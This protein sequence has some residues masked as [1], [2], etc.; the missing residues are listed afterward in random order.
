MARDHQPIALRRTQRTRQQ[1][2]LDQMPK[3]PGPASTRKSSRATGA[4]QQKKPA[5]ATTTTT[6]ATRTVG[7]PARKTKKTKASV[8]ESASVATAADDA[9]D[10]SVTLVDDADGSITALEFDIPIS[11]SPRRNNNKRKR[12]PSFTTTATSSSPSSQN[13]ERTPTTIKKVRR[14]TGT[15]NKNWSSSSSPSSVVHIL[16]LRT[17]ILDDHIKR[18]IRRNGLSAEMNDA[19]G[20]KRARRQ[21]TL[22]ELRRARDELRDR[23]AEIERLRELTALFGDGC[24]SQQ[25]THLDLEMELSRLREEVLGHRKR[26]RGGGGGDDHDDVELTSSPPV[27]AREDHDDDH[28]HDHD[29]WGGMGGMSDDG[30]SDDA[31]GDFGVHDF[32]DDDEF[33][34][35]SVAELDSGGTLG[36]HR[37]HQQPN[38]TAETRPAALH[39]HGMITLTPPSTSPAKLASSPVRQIHSSSNGSSS[40][41]PCDAGVQAA[42]T[43]SATD[44]ASQV[45]LPAP[46]MDALHEELGVLRAEVSSLNETLQGQDALRARVGEKLARHQLSAD[47][48]PSSAQAEGQGQDFELQLDIVLQDLAEKTGRLAELSD[49]LMPVPPSSSSSSTNGTATDNKQEATAQ[50][51]A[52]LQSVRDTLADLDPSVTPLPQSAAPTLILAATRLREL[53]A[54]LRQRTAAHAAE[55]SA[56]SADL[57]ASRASEAEK[58]TQVANLSA[59]IAHLADTIAALRDEVDTLQSTSASQQTDLDSARDAALQQKTFAAEA[60][61]RLAEA[62]ARVSLLS[63][64]LGERE[65]ELEGRDGEVGR[66]RGELAAA[67]VTIAKLRGDAAREMGRSRDVVRAMRAQMVAALRVGEGFLGEDVVAAKTEDGVGGVV[68]V[69]GGN[70]RV[71]AAPRD[72]SDDSGL[73]LEDLGEG[74]QLA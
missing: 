1:H 74:L 7:R 13:G 29:G 17:Q 30:G 2:R 60:E 16:P 27:A 15:N 31:G 32:D 18:R 51:S 37:Q 50:L 26:R 58:T 44:A 56:L 6:T 71:I 46:A 54:A 34:E 49:L 10:D 33:G 24:S 43:M 23:D 36:Q 39:L 25:Q 48:S 72:P 66:L 52:A 45:C 42:A 21:K 69:V 14:H 28:D 67:G 62:V 40:M 4:A 5:A 53:D 59:D 20:E 73:G 65:A 68:V 35:T 70:E 63:R 38:P 3:T 11:C 57:A 64:Q 41:T 55:L 9:T 19:Y 22:E 12:R 8:S 47:G 61:A